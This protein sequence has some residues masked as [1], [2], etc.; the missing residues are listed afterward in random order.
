MPV[1]PQAMNLSRSPLW[2]QWH[3]SEQN[4]FN[5]FFVERVE[6]N[7]HYRETTTVNTSIVEFSKLYQ[8]ELAR[9]RTSHLFQEWHHP[10]SLVENEQP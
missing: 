10:A 5:E 2:Y 7:H 8:C 6:I 1:Q 4:Q 9:H 3:D